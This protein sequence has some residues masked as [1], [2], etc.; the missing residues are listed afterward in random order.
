MNRFTQALTGIVALVAAC[1]APVRAR[2][3]YDTYPAHKKEIAL[4]I[5]AQTFEHNCEPGWKVNESELKCMYSKCNEG[6]LFRS[7]CSW[8]EDV[9][10]HLSWS[11]VDYAQ[12]GNGTGLVRL[13]EGPNSLLPVRNNEQGKALAEAINIYRSSLK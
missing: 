1:A 3:D 12:H 7:R 11:E 6:D 8:F 10:V 5:I 4:Y 2:Q 13:R 9:E